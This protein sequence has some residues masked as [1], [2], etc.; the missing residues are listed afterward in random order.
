MKKIQSDKVTAG[1]III[2]KLNS[3]HVHWGQ[4]EW[5][6]HGVCNIGGDLCCFNPGYIALAGCSE[7]LL[8]PAKEPGETECEWLERTRFPLV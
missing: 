8:C 6:R 2:A 5:V 7:I 1:M 3:G 4:V